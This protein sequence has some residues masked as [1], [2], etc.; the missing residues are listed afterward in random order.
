M[1]VI[2]L[3]GDRL[4]NLALLGKSIGSIISTIKGPDAADRRAFLGRVLGDPDELEKFGKIAR[5][6]PRALP[7]F[8]KDEDIEILKS[9]QPTLDDLREATERPGLTPEAAGGQLTPETATALGEAA[10]AQTVGMTPSELALEP[11]KV[12]AAGEVSQEDVTAGVRRRVTGLTPGQTAKDTLTADL[13]KTA[14][15]IIDELPVEEKEKIAL[16]AAIPSALL[17]GDRIQA[18]KERI[19]LAQM[20]IDAQT[21]E[22]A[23]ER[24]DAFRRSIAARW[25]ERTKTG[26]DEVWERFL[27]DPDA[28]R[29][30]RGLLDRS[31]A[32]VD[33][34][35]VR[36]LEV[37]T[38]FSRESQ[39]GK[40][41]DQSAAR[42]QIR[43]LIDRIEEKDSFGSFVLELTV[44][45]ALLN[46]LN[47]AFV[48][49]TAL[50]EGSI[51]LS[52]GDIRD[53]GPI[54][55]IFRNKNQPLRIID[56]Q[57]NEVPT[58]REEA[59]VPPGGP[60]PASVDTIGVLNPETVDLSLLPQKTRDNL[61]AIMNGQGT[62]EELQAFD[63]VSAQ[64][65]LD[66]RRNR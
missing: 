33:E 60:P 10:R 59:N 25:V 54:A 15:G 13:F 51:P 52:I 23:N 26:T 55:D 21:L 29:R 34:S 66:A 4:R 38:A 63:P 39:V 11:K 19:E 16:R 50:S 53:I 47:D 48:N 65:I 49:L 32:P 56:E 8:L 35:D 9:T 62:F 43:I 20:R 7:R 41:A 46:Q 22:R 27:Y 57:G 6:S 3:R 12:V 58:G 42:N 1:A 5:D 36:L 14:Q 64:L 18:H 30:A 61:I 17:E 2:D 37:A 45:E 24:T 44:R 28:G 40:I 31:I